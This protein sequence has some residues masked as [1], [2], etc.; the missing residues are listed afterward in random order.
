MVEGIDISSAQGLPQW[1]SV[2]AAGKQFVYIKATEGVGWVSPTLDGQFRD[3]AQAGLVTGLYHFARPANAP[4]ADADT[5]AAKVAQYSAAGAG[6][7]PPCL[8][9]ETGTGNL[10]DWVQRFLTRLRAQAHA[11]TVMVYSSANFFRD[12][13]G[14]SGMDA[15]TLLW[16][17][18][19]GVPAGHPAYLTPRVAL[20]QYADNGTVAGINGNVDLDVAL[21]SLDDLTRR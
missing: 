8:D 5:F 18:D 17:A 10:H 20:H 13:I 12:H 15:T 3:A 16:I 4:E 2:H 9:V 21:R 19:Y 6:H 7:L 14:E 11:T 1:Q